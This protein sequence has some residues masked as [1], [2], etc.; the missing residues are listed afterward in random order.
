MIFVVAFFGSLNKPPVLP[1]ERE[2]SGANNKRASYKQAQTKKG[3]ENKRTSKYNVSGLTPHYK[4]IR[5][6]NNEKRK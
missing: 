1:G 6:F 2:T 3:I 4:S 5:R